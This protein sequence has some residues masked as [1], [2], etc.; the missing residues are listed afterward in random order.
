MIR[1]LT[2]AAILSSAVALPAMAQ[3]TP[4]IDPA[5]KGP[6][7]TMT[8]QVPNMKGDAGTKMPGTAPGKAMDSATPSMK[9]GDAASGSASATI[10]AGSL[11]LSQ[12]DEKLW[13]GKPVYSSDQKNIGEVESFRRGA[14]GEVIGLNAGIGGFLGLGETHVMLTSSQFKLQ[15]DRVVADVLSADAKNLPK[16]TTDATSLPKA[17]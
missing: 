1:K 6:T 5:T 15:G 9:P 8:D 16:A 10:K 3:Q 17:K 11:V 4:A 12:A 7:D 2:L 14:N 13:I